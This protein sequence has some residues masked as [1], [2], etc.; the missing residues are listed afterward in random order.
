[1]NESEAIE[2]LEMLVDYMSVVRDVVNSYLN[3]EIGLK[4]L[5][6]MRDGLDNFLD[7]F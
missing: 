5:A 6:D 2:T 7:L 3:G 1:M 4:E